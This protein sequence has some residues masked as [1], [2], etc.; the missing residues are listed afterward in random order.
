MRLFFDATGLER[1]AEGPLQCGVAHRLG[2]GAGALA[3]VTLGRK[4]QRGM[5][6]GFPLLTQQQQ[7]ALRQRDVAVLVTFAAADVQEHAL[8]INVGNLEA[9][10]F[11]QAQAA[12]IDGGQADAMIQGGDGRQDAARF[13]GG[14]DDRE[15][16]LG[17]GPGQ[18]QFMR[19]EPAQGFFPKQLDGANGLGTG[20]AG[21][22]L[23]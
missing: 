9:Q 16:K 19:P 23:L 22:F 1:Q 11:A 21:D 20:L 4:E 13:G 14:Q 6:M 10:A 2:G 3:A 7:G 5:P 8:R 17:I 15:F 18:F 12:G